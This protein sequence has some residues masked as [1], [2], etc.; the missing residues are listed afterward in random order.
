MVQIPHEY[1]LLNGIPVPEKGH[2]G[3]IFMPKEKEQREEFERIIDSEIK[4]RGLF[5]MHTR[6]VPVD[7]SVLGH[8]ALASE[9]L[10]RQIFIVGCDNQQRFESM[11]YAIRKSIE[12]RVLESEALTAKESCYIASLS[13]RTLVYKGM[14]SSLQL[15]AYFKDLQSPYFTSAIALVH[16]RFSTNTFP[17]WRLA[18]PFRIIG[19]N[20]EI[21]TIRGNRFWMSTREAVIEPQNLGGME[22][23]GQ[24]I[25]PGMS[26]SASF[27]N[28]LEF[29]VQSGMSLPHALAM[30]MPESIS[31]ENPLS[32]RLRA[33]YEYHS[34]F[35][36][37]WD[38]PAAILFSDGRY[39]GG[40]LDRN[41]LRPARVIITKNGEMVV[42]SETGVLDIPAAEI[43]RR[44]RLKPGKIL[45]VDT[46]KG[47]ILIDRDIKHALADEHPY[48]EWLAENRIVLSDIK[49]GRKVTHEVDDLPRLLTAFGYGREDIDLILKPMA[50]TSAEPVAS[51]GNDA[52]PAILARMPQRFFNYF[53]QQFA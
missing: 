7:P 19:H 16:S 18:Q 35:M 3:V 33:F 1:I 26:D 21:N 49:S 14:L 29:F 24:V 28:A 45:M 17:Q 27:D 43:E 11:L 15:R 46:E 25:Q 23:I 53:R 30:L 20:G 52:A 40:M 32:A 44:S 10:I 47:E 50:M 12:R 2:Y 39:A 8:D 6:D 34:I 42:A 38:G 4:A 51:M 13:T 9:P 37:P 48:R 31:E 5:L 22:H 36:A 41:G